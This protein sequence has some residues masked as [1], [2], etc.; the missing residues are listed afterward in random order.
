MPFPIAQSALH[1]TFRQRSARMEERAGRLVPAAFVSVEAEI[2]ATRTAV[3]IGERA[4]IGTLELE[5]A[6]LQNRADRLGVGD[7][8]V[9]TAVPLSLAGVHRARWCR[10]TRDRARMLVAA[11]KAHDS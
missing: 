9:G 7:V 5:G 4:D 10:L 11:G 6:D 3:A 8:P 2:A 1:E